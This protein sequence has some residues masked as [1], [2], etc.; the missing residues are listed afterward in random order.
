MGRSPAAAGP[1]ES[2][3]DVPAPDSAEEYLLYQTLVGAWPLDGLG[4]AD[5]RERTVDY[6]VKARH[7]AKRF[8]SYINPN[9]AY[10]VAAE[11]FVVNVLDPDQNLAFLEDVERFVAGIASAGLSNSLAQLV[12]KLAA[13]GIPDFF[14]GRESWDFSLVDPDNRRLVDYTGRHDRVR[15]VTAEFTSG[16]AG[17]VEAWFANP[18]DGRIK[19]WLTVAGLGLR[20][21]APALFQAGDYQPLKAQGRAA[22]HVFAFARSQGRAAVLAVVGRHLV[23]LRGPLSKGEAWRDTFLQLPPTLAKSRLRDVFT[24]RALS[25]DDGRLTV[26]QLFRSLPVALLETQT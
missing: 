20:R 11:A 25:S 15:K 16:G 19:L 2:V 3:D 5:F 21:R 12:V 14:Q 23:G 1:R 9:L 6:M 26:D 8:T 13:P 4:D 10:E 24:G 7:E 17:A 22:S 18:N